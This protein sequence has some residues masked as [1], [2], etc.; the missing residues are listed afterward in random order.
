MALSSQLQSVLLRSLSTLCRLYAS[1]NVKDV[2][3]GKMATS[4]FKQ[5]MPRPGGYAPLEWARKISKPINC[6]SRFAV[7]L[8]LILTNICICSDSWMQGRLHLP[9]RGLAKGWGVLG[10]PNPIPLKLWRIKRVRFTHALRIRL[11]ELLMSWMNWE[12]RSISCYELVG[13]FWATARMLVQKWWKISCCDEVIYTECHGLW[14]MSSRVNEV[15][16][17]NLQDPPPQ[18]KVLATPMLPITVPTRFRAVSH[19]GWLCIRHGHPHLFFRFFN[20][21]WLHPNRS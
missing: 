13:Y 10:P 18:S 21:C 17:E 9:N 11:I 8:F 7:M 16:G 2:S 4:K 5:E 14:L 12:L 15:S 19:L 3:P 1:S 20:R 6:K